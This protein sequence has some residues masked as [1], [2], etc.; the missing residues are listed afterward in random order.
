MKKAIT[1]IL[2]S[3][4]LA[5]ALAGAS[6][7]ASNFTASAAFSLGDGSN[8]VPVECPGNFTYGDSASR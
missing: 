5:G 2:A 7:S 6:E 3:L 4:T 1:A 8:P